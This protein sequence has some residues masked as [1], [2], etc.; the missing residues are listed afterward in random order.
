[1]IGVSPW[2]H[3]PRKPHYVIQTIRE[4]RGERGHHFTQPECIWC[5]LLPGLISLCR[6]R[7]PLCFPCPVFCFL[8]YF[9]PLDNYKRQG[10]CFQSLRAPAKP[11]GNNTHTHTTCRTSPRKGEIPFTGYLGNRNLMSTCGEGNHTVTV[12][13][14]FSPSSLFEGRIIELQQWLDCKTLHGFR[15]HRFA[16]L[17]HEAHPV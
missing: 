1:M 14:F 12:C 13:S 16:A 6:N 5:L 7:S 9:F 4:Q 2:H 15:F 8:H 3:G 17:T 11:K 10:I